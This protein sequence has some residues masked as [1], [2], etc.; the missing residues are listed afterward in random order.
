M[1]IPVYVVNYKNEERKIKMTKR[2]NTLGIN[3][4]FIKEV[5]SDDTRINY[6]ID[7]GLKRIWSIMLQH[8]D[9]I[10]DF[11]ENTD[12]SHCI[13]CEDDI[14]I[15]KNTINDIERIIKNFDELELDVL[16]LGYL[17]PFKI[18]NNNN[19]H[20]HYFPILNNSDINTE[21]M[22][23]SYPDDIWGT[24]MYLISRNYAEFLLNKFTPQF[25]FENI[26]SISYNPDWIITKNGKR[27]LINPMIAVEEGINL[28]GHE[29]HIHFHKNCFDCNYNPDIYI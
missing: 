22:Y 11:F 13:V 9:C 29:A 15:S 28:S 7:I 4:I 8:L 12:K 25:A 6:D 16:M 21:Y 20:N 5:N 14:Y 17:L 1:N 27:A 2:F 26:D 3:P 23:H 24:Q 10:R 18:D 19:N